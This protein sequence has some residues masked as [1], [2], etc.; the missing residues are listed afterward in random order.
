MNTARIKEQPMALLA[1]AVGLIF[2]LLLAVYAIF[3][4]SAD[5][6]SVNADGIQRDALIK[7]LEEQGVDFSTSA[8]KGIELATADY[9]RVADTISP[10]LAAPAE[11]VGYGIF[12]SDNIGVSDATR[13]IFLTRAIQGE[14]ENTVRT[15]D[16]VDGVRAHVSLEERNRLG[17]LVSNARASV[18]LNGTEAAAPGVIT[19]SVKA[20]VKSVV[21]GITEDNISVFING[22][23]MASDSSHLPAIF[24]VS[25]ALEKQMQSKVEQLLL[26]LY[27][28]EQFSVQVTVALSERQV[29]EERRTQ[30]DGKG[31]AVLQRLRQQKDKDTSS[32]E[33]S[34]GESEVTEK[35]YAV[36]TA[37]V[38]ES[39]AGMSI[40]RISV[41]IL[42]PEY[43]S[44]K[45]IAAIERLVSQSLGMNAKRGDALAV[46]AL[47][48]VAAT[49]G[50]EQ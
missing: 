29:T 41:G 38:T 13:R 35:D 46:E 33:E 34:G 25:T 49:T 26:S 24:S 11:S 17:K 7:V 48:P 42:L 14:I 36:S 47:I 50:A 15:F 43:T 5:S 40:E 39:T 6:V 12:E 30:G 8:D 23:S 18:Y 3:L 45:S 32:G 44:K 1:L 2:V 27:R 20:L 19:R 21:N 10:L 9:N 22:E 31:G 16:G 37:L 4:A 28:A